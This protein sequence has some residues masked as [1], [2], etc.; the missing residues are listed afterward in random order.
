MIFSMRV[1]TLKEHGLTG[2]KRVFPVKVFWVFQF[3]TFRTRAAGRE[4]R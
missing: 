1:N 4:Y 2:K 3:F